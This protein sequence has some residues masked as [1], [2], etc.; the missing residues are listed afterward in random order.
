[1]HVPHN[2]LVKIKYVKVHQQVLNLIQDNQFKFFFFCHICSQFETVLLTAGS[3][4]GLGMFSKLVRQTCQKP[5]YRAEE[6]PEKVFELYQFL[7]FKH[8]WACLTN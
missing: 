7:G 4:A 8:I 1:M 3:Q 2:V 5:I 6:P